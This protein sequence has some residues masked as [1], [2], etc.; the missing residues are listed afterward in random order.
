VPYTQQ[1]VEFHSTTPGAFLLNFR[2]DISYYIKNLP[3]YTQRDIVPQ[4]STGLP[5]FFICKISINSC[6]E[7]IDIPCHMEL[8]PEKFRNWWHGVQSRKELASLFI[9]HSLAPLELVQCSE[10]CYFIWHAPLISQTFKW[11]SGL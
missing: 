7:P 5:I 11:L 4:Y 9:T 1:W 2:L 3:A 8:Q 6:T 10:R